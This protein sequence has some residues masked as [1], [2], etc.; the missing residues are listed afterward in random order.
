MLQ[1]DSLL[2]PPKNETQA[3]DRLQLWIPP[4]ADNHWIYLRDWK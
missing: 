1:I 4:L 2:H 3:L